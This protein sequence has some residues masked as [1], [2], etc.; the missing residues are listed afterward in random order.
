MNYANH[1]K[2]K[3]DIFKSSN[4]SIFLKFFDR[5]FCNIFLIYIKMFKNDQENKERLQK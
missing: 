4:K 1:K 5:F 3:S 2:F